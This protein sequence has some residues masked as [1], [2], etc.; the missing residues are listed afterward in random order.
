MSLDRMEV[1]LGILVLAAGHV[2]SVVATVK[3]HWSGAI[4]RPIPTGWS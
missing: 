1:V 4:Q 2:C 3:R